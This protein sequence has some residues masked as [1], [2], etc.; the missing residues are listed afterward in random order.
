MFVPRFH[1]RQST[2][3]RGYDYTGC[4]AY[5][6]TICASLCGDRFGRIQENT[7]RLNRHG[8]AL[9]DQWLAT[10]HVRPGVTLDEWVVMPDHFHA[11]VWLPEQP[12]Y[13]VE[14]VAHRCWR[15]PRSLGSLVAGFKSAVSGDIKRLRSQKNWPLIDVWQR[16]YHDHIVR[17]E[18]E[19]QLIRQYIANNPANWEQDDHR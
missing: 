3:L 4:G 12:E 17:N 8:Q 11:L 18:R 2:R 1:G 19:L 10:P 14:P 5:F 6:I 7:V 9:A 15:A 13:A 16:N